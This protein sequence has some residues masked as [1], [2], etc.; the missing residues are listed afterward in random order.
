MT[1]HC[2]FLFFDLM[3]V[4]KNF[5]CYYNRMRKINVTRDIFRVE[6]GDQRLWR[7]SLII[8]AKVV[9]LVIILI[10]LILWLLRNIKDVL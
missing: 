3:D 10:Y 7:V 6:S 2:L 9:Y 8:K 1:H 5:V 4:V